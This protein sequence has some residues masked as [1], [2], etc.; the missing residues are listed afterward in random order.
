MVETVLVLA[1][2]FG[3]AATCCESCNGDAFAGVL[4]SSVEAGVLMHIN[5]L[6]V[7][8]GWPLSLSGKSGIVSRALDCA[9]GVSADGVA[10][11]GVT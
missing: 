7:L 1:S 6:H 10:W 4:S 8:C 5:R 11:G 2:C 3:G 9:G